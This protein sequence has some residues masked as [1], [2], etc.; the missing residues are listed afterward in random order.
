MTS[1]NWFG[2]KGRSKDDDVKPEYIEALLEAQRLTGGPPT[3]WYFLNSTNKG[4]HVPPRLMDVRP[5]TGQA[6]VSIESCTDP[7]F[8][9]NT[10]TGGEVDL[11]Q[12]I[13]ADGTHGRLADVI[14]AGGPAAFHTHWQTLYSKGTYSGLHALEEVARRIQKHFG[15]H[16]CWTRCS[17]LAQYTVAAE[18]LRMTCTRVNSQTLVLN[19]GA[20]FACPDFTLSLRIDRPVKSVSVNSQPLAL[21]S[22]GESL[23]ENNYTATADQLTLCLPL[24]TGEHQVHVEFH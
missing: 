9:R 17:D 23:T 16:V 5:E 14:R 13:S 6:V 21:V 24:M 22:A 12:L 7:D 15:D 2:K 1:P 19:V 8:G 11:D 10:W 20:P 18:T 4:L 3:T